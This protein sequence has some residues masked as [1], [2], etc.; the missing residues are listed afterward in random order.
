MQQRKLNKSG[1]NSNQPPTADLHDSEGSGEWI[2][3][4]IGG[5]SR[6]AVIG[7]C[8]V[9]EA[10]LSG[11]ITLCYTLCTGLYVLMA[12]SDSEGDGEPWKAVE[13]GELI[14]EGTRSLHEQE[15]RR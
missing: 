1:P 7:V 8:V 9:H 5:V 14:E 6:R 2:T 3:M 11:S 12:F 10:R 13:I 15:H 4:R